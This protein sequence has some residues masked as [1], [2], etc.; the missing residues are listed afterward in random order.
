MEGI[1]RK[2]VSVW[3]SRSVNNKKRSE[4]GR[5]RVGGQNIE[6]RVKQGSE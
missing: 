1:L 2:A 5:G 6:I 4:G 3:Q